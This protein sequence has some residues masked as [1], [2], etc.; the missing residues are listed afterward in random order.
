LSLEDKIQRAISAV[1]PRE[2]R[3]IGLVSDPPQP[4]PTDID[5]EAEVLSAILSGDIACADLAPLAAEHFYAVIH[6]AVWNAAKTVKPGDVEAVYVNLT[7]AGWTGAIDA[8]LE[9]LTSAQPWRSRAVL[10]EQAA[11]VVELAKRRELIRKLQRM[12]ADLR[13]DRLTVSAA[14]RILRGERTPQAAAP[15]VKLREVSK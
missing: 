11:R 5:A 13:T 2:L 14:L 1:L 12:E 7:A 15:V 10:K 4:L 9:Q 6:Q 3:A 8:E